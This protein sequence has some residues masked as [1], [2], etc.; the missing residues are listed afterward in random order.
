MKAKPRN[1][2]V[3][4]ENLVCKW[5]PMMAGMPVITETALVMCLTVVGTL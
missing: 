3:P 5:M 2:W 1:L 4:T